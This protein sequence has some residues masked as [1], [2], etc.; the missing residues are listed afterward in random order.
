M[1][2][3]SRLADR[4]SELAV[5]VK[6]EIVHLRNIMLNITHIVPADTQYWWAQQ[7]FA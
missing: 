5:E 7:R 1:P 3:S 4:Q 6:V 2:S